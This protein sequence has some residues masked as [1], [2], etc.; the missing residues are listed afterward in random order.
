MIAQ[1]EYINVHFS[2]TNGI[3]QAMFVVNLNSAAL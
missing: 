3:N 1:R 2:A